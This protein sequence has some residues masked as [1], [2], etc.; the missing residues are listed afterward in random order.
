MSLCTPLCNRQSPQS[1]APGMRASEKAHQHE[2]SNPTP[3]LQPN[4][5][6]SYLLLLSLQ[7]ITDSLWKFIMKQSY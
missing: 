1:T 6:P 3:N 7:H 5:L 2:M 4:T